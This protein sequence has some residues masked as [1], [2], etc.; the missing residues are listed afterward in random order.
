MPHP[1][2]LKKFEHYCRQ[3]HIPVSLLPLGESD[4]TTPF[5]LIQ[6]MVTDLKSQSIN[7]ETY[8]R[9]NDQRINGLFDQIVRSD[10]LDS[11]SVS[12]LMR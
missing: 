3:Q 6:K 8:S 4:I 12:L 2:V 7:F 11:V 10:T 1:Q 9:I 5:A